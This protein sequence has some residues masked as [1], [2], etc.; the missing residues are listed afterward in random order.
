MPDTRWNLLDEPLIGVQ[1]QSTST[2]SL[3]LP[4]VLER[5]G[6]T[7]PLEFSSVQPHQSQAWYS[8]LVQLAAICLHRAGKAEPNQRAETWHAWLRALTES[9]CPWCLV[10][11]DLAE[12]AFLQPPVPE[13]NL[14][15]YK[16][17]LEFPGE[18]DVL[19]T[20]KNH[21]VKAQRIAEPRPEHWIYALLTVQT[22]QGYSGVGNYGI[23]RMN[24]APGSRPLV[25][26]T[27]SL[28]WPSRFSRD[29]RALLA[30]RRQ[31]G[32]DYGYKDEAGNALLWTM[33]WDG[34]ESAALADCDPFFIEVCRRLRATVED[35]RL[36]LY[37]ATTE[38]NRLSAK[39]R[40]GDVGDPWT[41]VNKESGKIL[42]VPK[43]GFTYARTSTL[44]F[45]ADWAGAA[46]FELREDDGPSPYFIA[47]VLVRGKG[48]TD[49]LKH[50][51]LRVPRSIR[52]LLRTEDG[53]RRLDTLSKAR[54]E[55]A[56]A[57]Q[58]QVLRPALCALVQEDPRLDLRDGRVDRWTTDQ[59]ARVD[60]VFFEQLWAD[61]DRDPGAGQVDWQRLL[62][63]IARDV[64]E[65]A[66]ESA[67][68][69]S[70]RRFRSIAAA[71][72][73]FGGRAWKHFPD[74][75][76]TAREDP[77]DRAPAV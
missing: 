4:Q 75:M 16:N 50:R 8:F 19:V 53:R 57:V 63:G 37:R 9:D 59:D 28:D 43:A 1:T 20:A 31:I 30:H 47:R 70:S 21:D 52:Q 67:P 3:S 24:G 22:L 33:A 32:E 62:L 55:A 77:H 41:P 27:P 35:S 66:I 71:E 11:E 34:K 65:A 10:V 14:D 58:R 44:L 49:G 6:A 12:P 51:Q 56:A 42:T 7:T 13:G 60:S 17:R 76:P 23:A 40:N 36:V 45:G 25:G 39:D 29:V 2:E 46:A 48:R 15:V 73:V 74:A 54:V 18:L 38:V 69:S 5:L 64:L 61:V 26:F 72:R 68:L